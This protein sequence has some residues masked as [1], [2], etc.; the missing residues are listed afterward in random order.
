M[1]KLAGSKMSESNMFIL[2]E[3]HFQSYLRLG[4][5]GPANFN[6]LFK[7]CFRSSVFK[8]CSKKKN[9]LGKAEVMKL[10]D[11][12]YR[13]L[14]ASGATDLASKGQGASDRTNARIKGEVDD[15]FL[16]DMKVRC[17]CGSSMETDLLIKT[18][19]RYRIEIEVEYYGHVEEH[20]WSE[21]INL[22]TFI[23][24]TF[25]FCQDFGQQH[26]LHIQY[27]PQ[28]F[29]VLQWHKKLLSNST[30]KA[31]SST[32]KPV[33]TPKS[34][35]NKAEGMIDKKKNAAA[36]FL[37]RIKRNASARVMRSGSGGGGGSSGSS[38]GGG[39]G[40]NMKDQKINS[41]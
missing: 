38:K 31:G 19:R 11:D 27:I 33:E 35:K 29:T 41:E 14:Q 4:L 17:L 5:V 1:R 16:A 32:N 36:D 23:F 39:G 37:K 15:S 30:H 20:H 12:T 2:F 18:V 40:A 24:D 13:K 22:N 3:L 8:I 26:L 25:V 21:S 28:V 34:D 10:V 7:H 9:V 6:F